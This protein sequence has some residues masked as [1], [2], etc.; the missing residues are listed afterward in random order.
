MLIFSAILT[1]Y[2]STLILQVRE[3]TKSSSYTDIGKKLYGKWGKTGVNIA[4]ACSQFG[5]CCSYIYFIMINISHVFYQAF[6]VD[7]DRNSVAMVVLIL[8]GLLVFV[9]R[10]EI[11]ASTHIFADV[12]ILLTVI[13]IMMFGI[14]RMW[15]DGTMISTIPFLNMH[16]YS[17]AIGFSVYAY[18][19]IGMIMPVQDI[20]KHPE[21]Y[22]KVVYAVILTVCLVYIIFG[23][24]CVFA[25]GSDM[26][27]P[28]ITDQLPDGFISYSIKIL[29]CL[30]LFFSYPL[31]LYPVNI[32]VDNILF[33]GWEKTPTRQ[34]CKNISR[35]IIVALSIIVTIMLG[36][37]L[38]KFLSILGALTCTPI[39][40]T[41]PALF[42]YKSSAK[43]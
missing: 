29:F 31:Q 42:H 28:L 27:T 40:F 3:D 22:H 34:F 1:T 41:F 11:F 24:F 23:Q 17:E 6:Y 35:S 39:A 2:C 13:I 10:I 36:D 26:K 7:W 8:F 16:S 30:N 14:G 37:K 33:M 25:W 38:D 32:I 21:T 5:F 15:N 18:E 19:G 43:T 20:T 12:M 9:R 4:L